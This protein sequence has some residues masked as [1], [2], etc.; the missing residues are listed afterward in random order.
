ML[1]QMDL[2]ANDNQ[3]ASLTLQKAVEAD[4]HNWR[5]HYL[6]ALAFCTNRGIIKSGKRSDPRRR[7]KPAESRRHQASAR[8]NPRG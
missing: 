1:G 7:V 5:A 2:E 8:K 6:L 3:Q 4:T